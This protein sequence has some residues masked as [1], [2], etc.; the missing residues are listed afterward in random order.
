[1]RTVSARTCSVL[2][3]K[4][5]EKKSIIIKTFFFNILLLLFSFVVVALFCF[6]C[7]FVCLIQIPLDRDSVVPTVNE[8]FLLLLR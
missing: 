4:R 2:F 6:V 3:I 5:T 7:L 8:A 1:M